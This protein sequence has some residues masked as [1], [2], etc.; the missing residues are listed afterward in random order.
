M[1]LENPRLSRRTL[2]LAGGVGVL[3]SAGC[4]SG[5]D[6]PERTGVGTGDVLVP[7]ADVP[8]GGAY[9]MSVDG[10][11]VLVVQP[12]AGTV[13]AFDAE[14]PH[15]GCS[16]RATDDGLVC[17]CHA[18]AFDP[19]TGQVLQGPATSPLTAIAVAV[20]GDDVVLG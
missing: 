4:T 14:C 11:R 10:R 9:E 18:S 3:G 1:P 12:T 5:P 20:S 15:Q 6:V 8:R 17:P 7:L 16:V 13:V 19:A 2:L